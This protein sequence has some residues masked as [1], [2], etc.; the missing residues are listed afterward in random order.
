MPSKRRKEETRE[1][2]RAKTARV[3]ERRAEKAR[4]R[5]MTASNRAVLQNTGPERQFHE[6]NVRNALGT[7]S[8]RVYATA[9]HQ[10][11]S[12]PHHASHA[13][14]QLTRNAATAAR[15]E[16]LDAATVARR[17]AA[18]ARQLLEASYRIAEQREPQPGNLFENA[19]EATPFSENAIEA[20]TGFRP[21]K[22]QLNSL[23]VATALESSYPLMDPRRVETNIFLPW[24]H[25][26]AR[27]AS[28]QQTR[29]NRTAR[30]KGRSRSRSQERR[31]RT[32]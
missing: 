24:N 1:R 16:A 7:M 28:E 19:A 9:Y 27:L 23:P 32:P 21:K 17:R 25:H 10:L 2:R 3:D 4:L 20:M 18:V 26:R 15:I 11:G 13:R 6:T 29:R 12:R 22:E 5:R 14:S 8:G 30:E 31:P